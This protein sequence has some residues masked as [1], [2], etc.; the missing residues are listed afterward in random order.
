MIPKWLGVSGAARGLLTIGWTRSTAICVSDRHF[1]YCAEAFRVALLSASTLRVL[2]IRVVAIHSP[3]CHPA[4]AHLSP[5]FFLA[6]IMDDMIQPCDGL[7]SEFVILW[8][9]KLTPVCAVLKSQAGKLGS[10]QHKSPSV[11]SQLQK[12]TGLFRWF[13]T[14]KEV[15]FQ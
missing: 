4:H 7:D 12:L 9:G 6:V 15:E 13:S 3:P 8:T 2:S 14:L 11:F 1:C 5:F 10:T